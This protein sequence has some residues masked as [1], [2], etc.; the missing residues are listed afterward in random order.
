MFH[1]KCWF[2][3]KD[4]WG[5]LKLKLRTSFD[6]KLWVTRCDMIW[7][8]HSVYNKT[9]F[10]EYFFQINQVYFWGSKSQTQTNITTILNDN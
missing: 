8:E 1:T 6:G 4:D 9:S 2:E 3:A 5:K 7:N 10:L